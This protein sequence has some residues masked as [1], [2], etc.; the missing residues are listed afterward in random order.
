MRT[1]DFMLVVLA[2]TLWGTG[3]VLGTV[4]S[5]GGAVPPASVAMWRMLIAGVVLTG[6]VLLRGGIGRLD[7]PARTRILLTGGL[8]GLFEVL[9]FTGISLAGVGLAT[10]VAIGSAP[11]WVAVGD[12]V[13]ERSWPPLRSLGALALA[14]AGLLALLGSSLGASDRAI[15]GVLVS[16]LTGASFAA[17]TVLNRSPVPGLTTVRLTALSFLSGG[18]MLLPVAAVLGWGVPAGV[19]AWTVALAMGIGS[20]ALAYV[21]YLSG[22]VTVPP[23]VAT[24]VTLLEPLVA[25]VLGAIVFA[26]RLGWWGALGGLA[27]AGAVVLLRPQRDE[28][29]TVP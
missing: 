17:V 24:V 4:L 27:L 19:E 21:A 12:A 11:V 22:L 29:A 15:A 6:W 1:R 9:Y 13:R 2:A 5:D 26:E 25:A 23:F 18:V 20:T 8:T 14:L 28:P 7:R 16:L 3:G 10:L